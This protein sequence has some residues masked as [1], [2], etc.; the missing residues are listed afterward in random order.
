MMHVTG[1]VIC[2]T[3]TG[4]VVRARYCEH[5]QNAPTLLS[6]TGMTYSTKYSGTV[7]VDPPLNEHEIAYLRRFANSRRMH[8]DCGPYLCEEPEGEGDGEP[9]VLDYNWPGPEQPGLWCRWEPTENGRG[10][11]WDRTENFYY[12][13]RWMAFLIRTFLAPGAKLAGELA[14]P[15][16]GRHYAPEFEHFTFDHVVNGRIRA[17]S[18]EDPHIAWQLVVTDGEVFL[19]YDGKEPEPVTDTGP[20]PVAYPPTRSAHA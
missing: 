10:I 19:H 5:D 18:V 16:E 2:Q 14:A 13:E 12:G 3:D 9:N 1:Q 20:D 4:P 11:R 7:A 8:V 6:G 15:I 17:R